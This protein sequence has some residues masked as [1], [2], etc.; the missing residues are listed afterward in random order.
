MFIKIDIGQSGGWVLIQM[1]I[2]IDLGQS[3]GWVLI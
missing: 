2:K 3:W 1:F